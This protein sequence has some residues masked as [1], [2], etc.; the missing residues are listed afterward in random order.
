MAGTEGL[1]P[2]GVK[3]QK[4]HSPSWGRQGNT[5]HKREVPWEP[6]RTHAKI[7]NAKPSSPRGLALNQSWVKEYI[8][9]REDPRAGRVWTTKQR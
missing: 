9:A 7:G 8:Q 1:N 3:D 2:F 5:A 4:V 6:K